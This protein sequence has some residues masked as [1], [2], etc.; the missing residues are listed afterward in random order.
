MQKAFRNYMLTFFTIP[1]AFKGHVDIIQRNS[2]KSWILL[3]PRPEIIVFGD[4]EGTK[5]VA[6]EFRLR[7]VPEVVRNEYGTPLLDDIF[8]KAQSIARNDNLCYIN[9]DIILM[10]DFMKAASVAIN[11]GKRF[12]MVGHRWDA[13]ISEPINFNKDWEEKLR[14]YVRDKGA[15]PEYGIDYFVFSRGFLE[16]MPPFILGRRYYDWW[17]VW[18]TNALGIP[19]IDASKQVLAV[20]QHHDYSFIPEFKG[21]NSPTSEIKKNTQLVFSGRHKNKIMATPKLASHKLGPKGIQRVGIL[22]WEYLRPRLKNK[23]WIR[24]MIKYFPFLLSIRKFL[25]YLKKRKDIMKI[26]LDWV[27]SGI[28]ILLLLPLLIVMA[29]VS[30]VLVF[31]LWL[32]ERFRLAR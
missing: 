12:V 18:E 22:E 3:K 15:I 26:G 14:G 9:A 16:N 2:I 29:I 25:S 1:K 23:R 19:L 21:F 31:A 24:T 4:D 10:S 5:E 32:K 7:Y 13:E 17:F 27:L 8:A 28:I 20:H 6:R 30:I 11:W